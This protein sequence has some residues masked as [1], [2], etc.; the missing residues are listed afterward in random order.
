M[1]VDIAFHC[2]RV[3]PL[4][5]VTSLAPMGPYYSLSPCHNTTFFRT[6]IRSRFSHMSSREKRRS[7]IT[8]NFVQELSLDV[9]HTCTDENPLQDSHSHETSQSVALLDADTKVTNEDGPIGLSDKESE[10]IMALPTLQVLSIQEQ[11]ALAATP[12][13]PEGLYALYATFFSGNFIEQVWNFAWPSAVAL[14]HDS[15]L[16]VAVISFVS[17]L[18]IFACGPWVGA[19]MDSLPRVFTFNTLSIVQTVAQLI[20]VGAVIYALRKSPILGSSTT[21]LLLQPWFIILV[22]MQAVERLTGLACGTA[23]ERDWVVLLAGANRPIALADANAMLCRVDYLC[24]MTG[25][26][27]YGI[28]LS[29]FSPVTCLKVAAAIM[30]ASLPI[31]IAL[32]CCTNRLS[33]CVLERPKLSKVREMLES[34]SYSARID[35]VEMLKRGWVRYLSQPALP[36]SLAAV[37]LF[38]NVA[39]APGSLMT[40]FLTQQGMNPS[41]IGAFSGIGA[42][43]GF[44]ATFLSSALVR[45]LGL[46]RSGAVGLVFQASLLAVAFFIYQSNSVTHSH[47]LQFFLA[48]IVLSRLG[49]FT[50]DIIGGQILQTAVH[51]SEA[52][53][54]G[55]TEVSLAS[56]AELLMLG[57]A[58]VANDVSH[59]GCLAALSL[60]AVVGATLAYYRWMSNMS[61]LLTFDLSLND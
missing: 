8:R 41:I 7:F 45:K 19:K 49:H 3:S 57:V 61:S 29:K 39:L 15:L 33:K 55:A 50:Y 60:A 23:F 54:V 35:A 13:H 26:S 47:S 30:L 59:F 25:T 12:A 27:F 32:A 37:F 43:M 17:K 22:V 9:S 10:I 28:L 52:N 58:I 42:M 2:S 46:L 34:Q 38:F 14:L 16:P 51:S 24:E 5:V 36:V 53:T 4:F 18:V 11:E 20:S 56:L 44:G 31:M 40:S 1:A 48:A 6:C 21:A